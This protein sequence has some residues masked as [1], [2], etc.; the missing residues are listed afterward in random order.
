MLDHMELIIHHIF[1]QIL[2]LHLS[3]KFVKVGALYQL[4][5]S[6]LPVIGIKSLVFLIPSILMVHYNSLIMN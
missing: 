2:E 1:L 4:A 5:P 6:L 3:M